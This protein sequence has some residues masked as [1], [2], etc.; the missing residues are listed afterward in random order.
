VRGSR[1]GEAKSAV[2]VGSQEGQRLSQFEFAALC[3]RWIEIFN[4]LPPDH[5]GGD[6]ATEL[7]T[8]PMPASELEPLQPDTLGSIKEVERRTGISESTIKRMVKDGRFPKPMRPSPRRI[9]W[10]GRDIDELVRQLDD[11]RRSPR[12]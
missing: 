7:P 2:A 12:Q 1:N 3:E 5:D 11:Q 8:Q 9:A 4:D 6:N 10:L